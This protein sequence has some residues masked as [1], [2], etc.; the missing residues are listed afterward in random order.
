MG[1]RKTALGTNPQVFVGK[2][3]FFLTTVLAL[4]AACISG[5]RHDTGQ[6]RLAMWNHHPLA[7]PIRRRI[8]I[9]LR[10]RCRHGR[11]GCSVAVA[12]KL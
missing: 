5:S 4:V 6:N 2:N 8:E 3:A 9:Q 12:N 11:A 7:A 10:L 1:S